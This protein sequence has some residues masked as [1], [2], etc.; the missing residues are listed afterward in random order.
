MTA[1]SIALPESLA[2]MSKVIAKKLHI[3]RSQLIR[4]ALEHEI[5][6]YLKRHEQEMLV[7]SFNAM[8]KHGKYLLEA[9][10][11][12]TGLNSDYTDDEGEDWWRS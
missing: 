4:V 6:A 9:D 12:M 10:A 1:I 7:E 11:I 3:S 5:Q 8:K 2:K